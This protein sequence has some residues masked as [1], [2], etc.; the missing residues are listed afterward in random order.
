MTRL[1]L[2][3]S[4][5][6]QLCL[7]F[8]WDSASWTSLPAL[9]DALLSWLGERPAA[10]NIP[11]FPAETA[12]RRR[13]ALA[14]PLLARVRP[15]GDCITSLGFSGAFH[16]LLNVDELDREVSWGLE[17]PWGTGIA[18]VLGVR[19]RT[20]IPRDPDLGRE[21]AWKVYREHGFALVGVPIAPGS[22]GTEPLPGCLEVLPVRAASW[23]PGADGVAAVR[24]AVARAASGSRLVRV[25]VDLSGVSDPG[26]MKAL[27]EGPSGLFS[28]RQPALSPLPEPS[29]DLP[30]RPRAAP[31]TLSAAALAGVPLSDLRAA[32]GTTASLSRKKRKK[33][34]EFGA[35]LGA[36][37]SPGNGAA[38]GAEAPGRDRHQQLVAH[39]LGEVHLSGSAF[40]VR[41]KGGRFCGVLCRG[42]DLLP[43]RPA[44]AFIRA[45]RASHL[46]RTLTSVSFESDHGT[47][48][49]EEIGDREGEPSLARIEYA[50]HD[51]SPD[52]VISVDTSFPELPA[53]TVME[54]YAPLALALRVLR[55]DESATVE[56]TAPDGSAT[57]VTLSEK[58]GSVLVPGAQHRIRRAD[59]GWIVLG[60][61][62]AGGPAWG[63]PSF[64]IH[65]AGRER[66]LECNPLG[67]GV[68]Q[69]AESL[70]GGS[71][72]LSLTLGL[73]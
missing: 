7:A 72:R 12:P 17:N 39:M 68:P 65:R 44:R 36:L 31:N 18:D 51:G 21:D 50:F 42:N 62:P 47:G 24:R 9:W 73:E 5:T 49:R 1:P 55:K 3:R 37:G 6:G 38:A 59:G 46:L 16:R 35:L 26:V 57:S 34:E 70:R 22:R 61:S 52:L 67:S 64:R 40:G 30:P 71:A 69:P 41:L 15:G 43:N 4:R 60:F 20:L 33:N 2:T 14:R 32:L 48:L 27:L 8:Q 19:P 28:G 58:D 29:G 45:G 56:A 13:A 53:G 11:A 23:L 25:L 66:I 63:L 54:E 10:W